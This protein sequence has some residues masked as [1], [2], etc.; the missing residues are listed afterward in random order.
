VINKESDMYY[1]YISG[2]GP[3]H[4][5]R[6][7]LLVRTLAGRRDRPGGNEAPIFGHGLPMK[8]LDEALLA[9][10]VRLDGSPVHTLGA[11]KRV[12][13]HYSVSKKVDP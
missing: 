8:A 6:Q 9:G 1:W 11:S 7:D 3:H 5:N 13:G 12:N 2:S 10:Y 4:G